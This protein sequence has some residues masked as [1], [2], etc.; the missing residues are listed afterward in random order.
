VC[1]PAWLQELGEGLIVLSGAQAGPVGQALVQ[2][3]EARA[4][5]VALQL[6]SMFPAPL[7][8]RAAARRAGR[9]RAHVTARCNWPRG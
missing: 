9:R 5:E 1:K 2:G 7:L 4:A 3:D 8:H 6:A